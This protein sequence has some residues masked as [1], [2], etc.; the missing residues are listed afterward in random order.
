[1]CPYLEQEAYLEVDF[2]RSF[3]LAPEV[4]GREATEGR[5]EDAAELQVQDME[6]DDDTRV[7]PVLRTWAPR[8]APVGL[9]PRSVPAET[10]PQPT[11]RMPQ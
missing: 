1:M 5:R 8:L 6:H 11:W 10:I 4:T 2:W 9:L 3:E 7:N